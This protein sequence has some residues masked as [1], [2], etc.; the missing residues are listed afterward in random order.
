MAKEKYTKWY[1]KQGLKVVKRGL[2]HKCSNG[3]EYPAIKLSN[4][5]IAVYTRGRNVLQY[6][7]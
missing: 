1:E 4:G 7:F 2:R 6:A 5:K 3:V